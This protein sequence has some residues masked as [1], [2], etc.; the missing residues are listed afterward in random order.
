[1]LAFAVARGLRRANRLAVVSEPSTLANLLPITADLSTGTSAA[2]S[3]AP[4]FVLQVNT[5]DVLGCSSTGVI[6]AGK[7]AMSVH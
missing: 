6:Y 5:R 3:G 1:M 2:S 4:T 7:S